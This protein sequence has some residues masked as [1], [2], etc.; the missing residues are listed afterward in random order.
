[1]IYSPCPLQIAVAAVCLCGCIRRSTTMHADAGR[2]SYHSHPPASVIPILQIFGY[3]GSGFHWCRDG[4]FRCCF[5]G[6]EGSTVRMCGLR[7]I[8]PWRRSSGGH[9]GLQRLWFRRGTLLVTPARVSTT[10]FF[11]PLPSG[12]GS[13]VMCRVRLLLF[14]DSLVWW[15]TLRYIMYLLLLLL[16]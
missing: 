13:G 2:S 10:C 6:Y 15:C 5:P 9:S 1:L 16:K 8:V 14:G 11:S 4:V 7:V 3:Q 12:Q